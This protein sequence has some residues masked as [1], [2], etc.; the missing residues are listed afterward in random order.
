YPG[1]ERRVP[2]VDAAR[3]H[4]G[5]DGITEDPSVAHLLPRIAQVLPVRRE[6][7]REGRRFVDASLLPVELVEGG[8]PLVLLL[9]FV[10]RREFVERQ[11]GRVLRR[12]YD[13]FRIR[14]DECGAVV[15]Y[16][17]RV[18]D[19]LLGLEVP[20]VYDRNPGVRLVV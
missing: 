9:V 15:G 4:F 13:V 19:Y 16:G 2:F 20:E 3:R 7:Y 12:L 8:E 17:V 5:V 6:L 11:R 1:L 14:R 18:L 10:E